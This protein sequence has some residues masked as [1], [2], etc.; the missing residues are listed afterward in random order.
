MKKEA[1]AVSEPGLKEGV[2]AFIQQAGLYLLMGALLIGVIWNGGYFPESKL[3]LACGLLIAGGWEFMVVV[4]LGEWQALR[5]YALWILAAFALWTA[6]S[7]AWTLNTDVT[8]REVAIIFGLLGAI[9]VP[10][11]QVLRLGVKTLENLLNWLIYSAGFVAAW[12]IATYLTRTPPY[13]ELVD[14]FLRVGSTFQYSNAVSC[15]LLM[16]LPVTLAIHQMG[17]QK[18]RALYGVAASLEIAAIF[19]AFSR[20]GLVVLAAVIV[21]FMVTAGKRQLLSQMAF[22]TGAGLLMAAAALVLGEAE[23]ARVGIAAVALLCGVCWL[24]LRAAGTERGGQLIKKAMLAALAVAGASAVV[25]VIISE[26]AQVILRTRFIE[27]FAWSKLIPH[28][29]ATW[30]AAW[31]AFKDKPVKGWGLGEFYEIFATYETAQPTRFAHNLVLQMAVDTGIVGGV[32]IIA[33]FVYIAALTLLRLV[34]R[35][36]LMTRALAIAAAVFIFYNM[37][38]WEWYLPAITAWF[39]VAVACIENRSL[40]KNILE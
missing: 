34:T 26:R 23:Y 22:I 36:N 24:I 25:L 20:M 18:D 15:F 33:L 16:A 39:M 9:L 21:Y 17:R 7:H 35:T 37:F 31:N 19:L 40:L 32:M 27:G 13:M 29:S 38:D 12:G 1:R 3:V 8:D 10:R 14:G 5:S 2:P 4:A 6:A 11:A 30:E 28:R